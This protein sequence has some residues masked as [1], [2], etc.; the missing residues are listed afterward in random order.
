MHA[1][2][3]GIS[4]VNEDAAGELSLDV[5]IELLHIARRI[6]SVGSFKGVSAGIKLRNIAG[7]GKRQ[8][9]TWTEGPVVQTIQRSVRRLRA[10]NS[11]RERAV[12]RRQRAVRSAPAVGGCDEQSRGQVQRVIA[13]VKVEQYPVRDKKDA[14]TRANDRFLIPAISNPQA[15]HKFLLVK[16]NS[17]TPR[18]NAGA[19]EENIARAWTAGNPLPRRSPRGS[20]AAAGNRAVGRGGIPIAREVMTLRPVSRQ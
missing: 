9:E 8:I 14:V 5:H 19:N 6:R 13:G 20:Y 3:A 10:C 12:R 17:G 15:R 7:P 1:S 2:G 18:V 16:R 4:G 11:R